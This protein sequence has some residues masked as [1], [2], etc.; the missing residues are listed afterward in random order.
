MRLQVRK[1]LGNVKRRGSDGGISESSSDAGAFLDN[2][3][4][5]APSR[6][7]TVEFFGRI[8]QFGRYFR[9]SFRTQRGLIAK[10]RKNFSFGVIAQVMRFPPPPKEYRVEDLY[11][12]TEA[13][14]NRAAKICAGGGKIPNLMNNGGG[15][16]SKKKSAAKKK[17]GGK[18]KKSR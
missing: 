5:N 8:R 11:K 7:G 3:E 14:E 12:I 4:E 13:M 9:A 15:G 17:K 10:K 16:G 6:R 1:A 18:K 2:A